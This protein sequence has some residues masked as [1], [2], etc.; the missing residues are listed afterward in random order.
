MKR[1][2]LA[3]NNHKRIEDAYE[4]SEK[5]IAGD[6]D[7]NNRIAMHLNAY[8]SIISLIP[9]T[10]EKFQSGH[11][12][13]YSESHYELESSFE[14]CKQGLYKHSSICIT[15]CFENLELSVYILTKTIKHILKFRVA[16]I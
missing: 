14:L 7:L 1:H 11:I 13:P 6:E 9:E 15:L 12:F 2:I 10:A 8:N 4:K 5:Y 16:E 3:V